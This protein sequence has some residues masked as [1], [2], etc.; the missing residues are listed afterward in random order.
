MLSWSD[1]RSSRRKDY[2]PLKDL[3]LTLSTAGNQDEV[4]AW[5][6]KV[7]HLCI[8]DQM[9]RSNTEGCLEGAPGGRDSAEAASSSGGG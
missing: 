8:S 4:Y 3:N 7:R 5:E 6:E 1:W 2:K 9:L